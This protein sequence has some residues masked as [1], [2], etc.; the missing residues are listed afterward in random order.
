M[1]EYIKDFDK[2]KFD[3]DPVSKSI[4][5]LKF[6]LIMEKSKQVPTIIKYQKKYLHILAYQ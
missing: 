1:S 6:N 5:K 4:L 2:T 3:S